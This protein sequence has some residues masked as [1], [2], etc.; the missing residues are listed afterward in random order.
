MSFP[1]DGGGMLE[2]MAFPAHDSMAVS[3][4]DRGN[5]GCPRGR[6]LGSMI[7]GSHPIA[8]Q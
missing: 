7:R 4:K 8:R 6:Y 1:A 3:H 5:H 2:A